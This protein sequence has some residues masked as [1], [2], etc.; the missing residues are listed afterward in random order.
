MRLPLAVLLAATALAGC[1]TKYDL[2]GA[3][4]SKPGTLIQTVTLDQME[5]V[6]VAR[7]AGSTPELWVGGLADVGRQLFEEGQRGGVYQSCM[8][9]KGYQPA[10]S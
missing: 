7:E 2:S 6:R 10:G 5:C 8:L 9:T 4:W 1:T 3:D